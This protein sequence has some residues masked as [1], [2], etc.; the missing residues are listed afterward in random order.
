MRA[1]A[2]SCSCSSRAAM[3]APMASSS[4]EHLPPSSRGS[5]AGGRQVAS[6]LVSIPW[7]LVKMDKVVE[8]MDNLTTLV[9]LSLRKPLRMA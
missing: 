6:S 2:T 9:T 8:Q 3:L 5:M 7:N 4:C 1:S